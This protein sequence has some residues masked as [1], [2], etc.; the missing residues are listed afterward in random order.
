MT[1]TVTSPLTGKALLQKAK[2]ET[3]D[4]VALWKK[5]VDHFGQNNPVLDEFETL[6]RFQAFRHAKGLNGKEG[7]SDAEN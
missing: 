3:E 2:D 1:D 4:G 7:S 5:I 6:R